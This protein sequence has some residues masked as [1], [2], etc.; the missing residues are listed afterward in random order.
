MKKLWEKE[1]TS[2]TFEMVYDEYRQLGLKTDAHLVEIYSK[3]VA[4][5][6]YEQL[7]RVEALEEETQ[8]SKQPK[9]FRKARLLLDTQQITEAV[10]RRPDIP[11]VIKK[12][13]SSW[14]E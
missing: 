7:L 6:S 11:T 13:G 9:E 14:V 1:V 12:W 4:L 2:F 5:K 3:P 8:T 10:T